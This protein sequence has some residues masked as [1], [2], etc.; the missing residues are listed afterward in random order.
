METLFI[1]ADFN[2]LKEPELIGTLLKEDHTYKC[3]QDN[4][5]ST[6]SSIGYGYRQ[7]T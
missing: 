5:Y 7:C 6:Q 1:Y 4:A 2:W 3:N